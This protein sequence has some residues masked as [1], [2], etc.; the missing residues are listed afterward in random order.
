MNNVKQQDLMKKSRKAVTPE[1]TFIKN[2]AKSMDLT[3]KLPSA[4][5]CNILQSSI[6]VK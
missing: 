6:T 3:R 1:R 5:F 2:M 4:K